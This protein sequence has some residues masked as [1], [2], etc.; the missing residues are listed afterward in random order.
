MKGEQSDRLAQA[1]EDLTQAV[2]ENTSELQAVREAGSDLRDFGELKAV[3]DAI[4]DLRIEYEHAFRNG[5]CPYLAEASAAWHSH[6][7][8]PS[9]VAPEMTRPEDTEAPPAERAATAAPLRAA[10]EDDRLHQ[11]RDTIACSYCRVALCQSVETA[12]QQGWTQ[13]HP[14]RAVA[15]KYLGIC[16]DCQAE[17]AEEEEEPEEKAEVQ[18]TLL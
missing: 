13:L 18:R 10:E 9:D 2:A 6:P 16:P 17:L 12:F 7:A 11:T 15:R 14:D 8:V 3:R 1:L 5:T 4:D